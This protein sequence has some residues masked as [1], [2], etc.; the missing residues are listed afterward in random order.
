MREPSGALRP[1]SKQADVEN[2]VRRMEPQTVEGNG[3]VEVLYFGH[4]LLVINKV[5]VIPVYPRWCIELKIHSDCLRHPRIPIS[6][7]HQ[8]S[9]II[10]IDHHQSLSIIDHRHT[11]SS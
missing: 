3:P 2:F 8:S 5:R 7:H 10:I 9:S 6:A 1:S 4:G 11:S